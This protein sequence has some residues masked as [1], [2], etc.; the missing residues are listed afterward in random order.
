MNP[1]MTKLA[2]VGGGPA[3]L[4][5]AIYAGRANLKPILISGGFEGGSMIP[6]GQLMITTEVENF[7]GFP[8]GISGPE[9]MARMQQ[10]AAKFGADE[11]QEFAT[12]FEF[13]NNGPHTITL[14][15][16]QIVIAKAVILAMGAQAKWLGAKDEAKYIN[17]GIS[18][19]ATCDGP[20]PMFRDKPIFVVGGGDSAVEEATFLTK[21][22]SRV[23]LV[24]RRD[25]LRASKIMQARTAAEPK[26]EILWN[27][28]IDEYHGDEKGMLES[29]TI[30][31]TL[32][33]D[34]DDDRVRKMPATGVFMAIGHSPCTKHLIG[35]GIKLDQ[36]GYVVPHD[37]IGTNIP[38]VFTAGDIHDTHFRQA[39][40]AAGFG[41]MASIAAERW[42]ET[43][44]S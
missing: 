35:T 26:L 38:G 3:G 6:G 10:Q 28:V 9:L 34:G 41:C 21:F 25:V 29:V 33:G 1:R 13:V 14:A 42:L 39:V 36:T 43:A 40:S 7:P 4:T 11:I 18:A 44:A 32:P 17:N 30:R 16:G 27:S 15:D 22:A 5:A 31:S 8:E 12:K 23:Y 24:V 37:L 2:I 19:C 20:L